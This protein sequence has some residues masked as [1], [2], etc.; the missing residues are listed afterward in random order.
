M[1]SFNPY[2][3]A[4]RS[5]ASRPAPLVH[6]LLTQSSS[7]PPYWDPGWGNKKWPSDYS[8]PLL[9]WDQKRKIIKLQQLSNIWEWGKMVD[10][11]HFIGHFCSL[12]DSF[13]LPFSCK[14]PSLFSVPPSQESLR[15]TR[16]QHRADASAQPL[17]VHSVNEVWYWFPWQCN[18]TVNVRRA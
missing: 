10:F 6:P 12:C 4:L 9:F 15:K 3:R 17:A 14:P 11:S 13:P 2:V 7:I 18:H 8:F 16:G 5:C 1:S